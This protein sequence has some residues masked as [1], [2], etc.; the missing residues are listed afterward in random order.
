MP[1]LRLKRL[2]KWHL[3]EHQPK[4]DNMRMLNTIL[5]NRKF[6]TSFWS[7]QKSYYDRGGYNRFYRTYKRLKYRTG[8]EQYINQNN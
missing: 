4:I 2:F 3:S 1:T 5:I 8:L 7:F 6:E